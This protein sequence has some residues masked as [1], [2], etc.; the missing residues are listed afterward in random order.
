MYLEAECLSKIILDLLASS[1]RCLTVSVSICPNVPCP[2]LSPDH[3]VA[4]DVGAVPLHPQLQLP[5]PHPHVVILA[6]PAP[7]LVGEAVE[8]PEDRG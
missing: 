6:A 5:D 4:G 1:P 7:E 3:G 2:V 8:L